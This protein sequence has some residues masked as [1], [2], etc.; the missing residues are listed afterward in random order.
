M[1]S[2]NDNVKPEMTAKKLLAFIIAWLKKLS[3]RE[4]LNGKL[5][6][7]DFFV[8]QS[9]LLF[10]I[11]CLILVFISFRYYCAKR[12]TEMDNLKIELSR[13]QNEQVDLNNRLTKISRQARIEELLKENGI[14]L[15]KG[16]NTTVYQIQK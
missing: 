4:I 6:T 16:N 7:E 12:I 15:T 9:K 2:E 1:E 13:L 3:L 11:F 5:L 8:K 14:E 10:L